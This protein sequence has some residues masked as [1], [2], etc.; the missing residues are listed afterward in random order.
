M[1]KTKRG[2]IPEGYGKLLEQWEAK[3]DSGEPIGCI[4]TTFTFSPAFFE[5]ECL[6]RFLKLETDAEE[7]GPL[8]LVER[9]EK[10]AQVKC[11]A[12]LVDQ[13]N[14]KGARSLRWDLHPARVSGIMHAKISLLCWSNLVRLIIGS[15]NMTEDGYRRNQEVFGVLDYHEGA[16]APRQV[17]LDVITYLREVMRSSQPDTEN[18][19]VDRWYAFL[20]QVE[21]TAASW[22]QT[23]D[24]H[25]RKPLRVAAILI[26]PG[27]EHVFKQ[28]ND[29]WPAGSPP[30]SA[31]VLSPFFDPP[32]VGNNNPARELWEIMR[33]RGDAVVNYCLEME[34]VPGEKRF[35]ARAPDTLLSVK[36]IRESTRVVIQRL[37]NDLDRP[38]HAKELWFEDDRF[39]LLM[40]GSSNFTSAGMGVGKTINY[41][42]NLAYVLDMNKA[43]NGY[44]D[45]MKRFPESVVVKD[46]VQ[47]EPAG[48]GE[49]ET[50]ETVLLPAGFKS[51][52]YRLKDG[53]TGEV[54]L[55]L[56][57][58]LPVG[59][60]L[61][62]DNDKP[63]QDAATWEAVG[64]PSS[65]VV[66]WPARAPSG[67]WV[68]W[69]NAMG[70]AWWPVN[71]EASTDLPPPDEL[72]ELPLDVLINLLTSAR[73]LHEVLRRYLRKHEDGKTVLDTSFKDVDPLK[74][75]DTSEF[76]LQR[77]R[78]FSWALSS[79]GKRLERPVP[80]E[81]CLTWRIYGPV[82]VMAV[83]RA[84]ER[85]AK[86]TEERSFLMAELALELTRV[87]PAEVPGYLPASRVSEELMKSAHDLCKKGDFQAI[88]AHKHLQ[89]YLGLVFEH[90]TGQRAG[91]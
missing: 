35:I 42:A 82:G 75:V 74:R 30:H 61:L 13:H 89:M 6:G 38:L 85:D 65:W 49:D 62:F 4:A 31:K 80:T 60:R 34:E 46:P 50:A 76:L 66:P 14:C 58:D 73:P 81:E 88:S 47:F 20:D 70:K 41:E 33:K 53:K 8:Y 45:L 71:V 11:A 48:L 90:I 23:A 7:D 91:A 56:G 28:L 40:T 77:T 79:L 19:A 26:R 17:L 43:K 63:W 72:K 12:V 57:H 16:E 83:A 36:P 5:E 44:K 59:W 18:K 69:T 84:L 15:A 52:I 78:R 3:D 37:K 2:D 87:S 10:L 55:E 1:S 54:V 86:S 39:A 9:E 32:K 68:T 24:E 21:Q 51:A 29:L 27:G 25:G 67:I 22:G 64:K